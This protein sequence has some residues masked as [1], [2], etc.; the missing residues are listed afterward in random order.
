MR[1]TICSTQFTCSV[2]NRTEGVI[3]V[4]FVV[5]SILHAAIFQ[6]QVIRG[7]DCSNPIGCSFS[8]RAPNRVALNSV[9]ITDCDTAASGELVIPDTIEGNPV[10][11]IGRFAFFHCHSLTSITFLGDALFIWPEE[12]FVGLPADA[13]LTYFHE[14][15]GY[16]LG[17]LCSVGVNFHVQ[18]ALV[19]QLQTAIDEKDAQITQLQAAYDAVVAERD[20]CPDLEQLRD[21]RPGSV[22]LSLDPEAGSVV[23][24]FTVEESED[25]ITWTPVAGP[26]VS[27]TLTLPEGKRFYRFAH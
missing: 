1:G 13:L 25:L 26:G 12:I 21:G 4:Q 7:A 18:S 15:A 8:C 5:G 16:T 10:T 22:L 24:D 2:H 27:Q 17:W 6:N 20:A 9:P 19:D 11:S 14:A 3:G 23:L